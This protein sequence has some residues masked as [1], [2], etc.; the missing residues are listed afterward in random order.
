LVFEQITQTPII[1]EEFDTGF[2]FDLFLID[3][4]IKL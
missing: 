3:I 2:G 1:D 4:S